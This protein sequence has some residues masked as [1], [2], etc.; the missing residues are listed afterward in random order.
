MSAAR[1]VEK[2]EST[3][4]GPA[5]AD[6]V[7][8]LVASLQ[9]QVVALDQRVR[10]LEERVR[11]LEGKGRAAAPAETASPPAKAPSPREAHA[12]REKARIL[13]ALEETGWNKLA[14]AEKLGIPR[15][16]FYRKLEAFGID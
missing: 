6:P 8:Q 11:E 4:A 1:R 3:A 7:L 5:A 2:G 9:Q 14:A 15:R 16:T 10:Q 13:K 12:E